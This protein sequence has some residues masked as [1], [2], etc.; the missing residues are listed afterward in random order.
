MA[1][2][3]TSISMLLIIILYQAFSHVN[4]YV[5]LVYAKN[6]TEYLQSSRCC[7][8]SRYTK[9][10]KTYCLPILRQEA[11]REIRSLIRCQD[12]IPLKGP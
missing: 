12:L 9:M 3:L 4:G 10:T 8:I 2:Y 7:G 1:I 6:F 11:I 5:P